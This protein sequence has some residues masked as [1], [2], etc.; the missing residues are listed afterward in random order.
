LRYIVFLSPD[1][2]STVHA[3][4]AGYGGSI[5]PVPEARLLLAAIASTDG[6]CLVIDPSLVTLAIA[7][8]IAVTLAEFPRPVV[9]LSAITA[10]ALNSAVILTQRSQTRFIFRGVPAERSAL[11]RALLLTPD[12]KL[13]TTL[14]SGIDAQMA[15]LPSVIRNKLGDV[16]L[17][18]DSPH[19]LDALAATM[20][21]T[22]RS[23]DRRLAGAGFV[24]GK[25]L[26]DA[27]RIAAAYRAITTSRVPLGRIA[28][29]LGCTTRAM[30]AQFVAMI[31]V[32]CSALRAQPMT[33]EDVAGRIARRLTER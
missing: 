27:W 6:D 16:L 21:L 33:A 3:I 7:E 31:G 14:L 28:R 1:A 10:V 15:R 13:L 12:V 18:G 19:S 22:R 32:S 25:R 8:T 24:S 11:G 29:A 23:I 4:V 5:D 20:A 9:A 17:T 26:L 30:D 2:L